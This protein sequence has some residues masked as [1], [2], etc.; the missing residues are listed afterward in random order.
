MFS[1]INILAHTEL[2]NLTVSLNEI[3]M[4]SFS[5]ELSVP[6]AILMKA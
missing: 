6:F 2:H 3:L 1:E 4:L 5:A